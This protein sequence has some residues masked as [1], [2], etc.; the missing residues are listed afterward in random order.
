MRCLADNATEVD[1][2]GL[3]GLEGIADIELKKLAGTPRRH[4]E[5]AIVEGEVD[6]AN[7]R[8]NC[9]EALE[10]RRQVIGIGRFGRD[11]DHLLHL[12]SGAVEIPRP[13]RRAEVLQA[14]HH[15]DESVRL[16]WIVGGTKLEHHLLL[17]PEVDLLAMASLR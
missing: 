12:V 2:A 16:A 11:L 9:L 7:Q 8:R 14:H 4:V 17:S 10:Q 5:P 6:V 1:A 15:T 13:D 3:L